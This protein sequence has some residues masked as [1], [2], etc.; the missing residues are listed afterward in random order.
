MDGAC[1]THRYIIRAGQAEGP[2]A[3]TV[4]CAHP[5]ASTRAWPVVPRPRKPPGSPAASASEHVVP[6]GRPCDSPP[7]PSPVPTCEGPLPQLAHGLELA[8][9]DGGVVRHVPQ[10]LELPHDAQPEDDL[11]ARPLPSRTLVARVGGRLHL[12]LRHR[13]GRH[14]PGLGRGLLLAARHDGA[15][16]LYVDGPGAGLRRGRRR[17]RHGARC[18]AWGLCVHSRPCWG[19]RAGEGLLARGQATPPCRG[20]VAVVG[21]WA[22]QQRQ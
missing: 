5:A 3:H 11:L 13:H 16:V 12:V 1:G 9:L 20:R 4:W 21:G 17:D 2:Q 14:R 8:G 6:H 15:D 18:V 19:S 22:P 10:R 7:S